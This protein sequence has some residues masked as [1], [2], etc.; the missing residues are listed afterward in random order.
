MAMTGHRERT[1]PGANA[2]SCSRE[3][4]SGRKGMG[5][6]YHFV[7]KNHGELRALTAHLSKHRE[8]S[9]T[10]QSGFCVRIH[11]RAVDFTFCPPRGLPPLNPQLIIGPAPLI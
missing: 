8:K 2:S 1:V 4:V 3:N 10:T 9:S 11:N 6:L 7:P 5:Y